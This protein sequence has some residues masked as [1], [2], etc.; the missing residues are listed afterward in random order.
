MVAELLSTGR[1]NAM[2]TQMLCAALGLRSRRELV[3]IVS[4]ERA[5]GEVICSSASGG[6][7]LPKDATEIRDF[8]HTV[9]N[10]GVNTLAALKSARRA[11]SQIEG[12]QELFDEQERD[13]DGKTG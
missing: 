9:R 4:Q 7:Y 12:Q 5:A 8:I 1:E 3:K 6:Y 10:R 11:L 2:S 13:L